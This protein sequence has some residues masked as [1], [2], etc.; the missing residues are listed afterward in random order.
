MDRLQL[1]QLDSVPAVIRT[2]YMPFFSRLG[3][4]RCD[5]LDEIAYGDDAWFEAWTHEASLLPVDSEPLFRWAKRRS[6][7]GATWGGLVRLAREEP[8]YVQSVLDEVAERGPILASELSDPRPQSGEW[9]GSRSIGQ[10]ALDWLWR[11]GAVGIRRVGNFEK[12]FDLLERIIPADVRNR[13]TPTDEEAFREL[14]LRSAKAHGVGTADCLNDYFR[15]PPREAK[16]ILKDLAAEG[17]LIECE[18]EGWSKPAYRHPAVPMPRSIERATLLSP[19][20]PVV[21][22][23]ARGEN[24]F[25]FHYRIEIYVPAK[26]RHYGYYV[27]PMLWGEGLAGRFD[28]KTLRDERVLHVKGSFAE[29]DVDVDELA[30]VALEELRRLA[31]FVGADDLRIERRGNLAA[32][33]RRQREST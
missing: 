1:L 11:I 32:A 27:L 9:W 26:K 30:P 28:L 29:D 16:P 18:I 17:E 3:V 10:L 14:M 15:L 12:Q 19:F 6:S 21:W 23:R 7:E 4:Y 13:P 25:D 31:T 20:D 8:T 24:L 33:L 5:L 2:Q 22:N